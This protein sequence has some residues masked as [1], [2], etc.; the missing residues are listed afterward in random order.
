MARDLEHH[1]TS[2]PGQGGR[3]R[4]LLTAAAAVILEKGAGNLT[5]EAVCE[6]AHVSKGGL[7]YYFDGKTALVEALVD[8][9]IAQ[10]EADIEQ[11]ASDATEGVSQARAY[12]R[13]VARMGELPRSQQLC[14]ALT[15]ICAAQPEFIHRVQDNIRHLS[16]LRWT[17][18]PASLQELHLRLVADG[19]WLA[20]IYG[21]YSI[22][23]ERRAELLRWLD[24]SDDSNDDSNHESHEFR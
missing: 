14:K 12:L 20:D 2:S 19:L 11:Q 13:A 10:L 18:E 9:L 8:D 15:F 6:A 21:S 23:P 1:L 7:L 24:P 4:Q 22:T 16:Q 5:L 3:R 17:E